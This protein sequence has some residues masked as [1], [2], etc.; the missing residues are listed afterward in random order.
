MRMPADYPH[1][2]L[3]DELDEVNERFER[4]TPTGD[5][6]VDFRTLRQ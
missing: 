6:L 2:D 5:P 4:S 3:L 1:S